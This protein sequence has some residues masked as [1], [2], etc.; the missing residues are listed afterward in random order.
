MTRSTSEGL[1]RRGFLQGTVAGVVLLGAPQVLLTAPNAAAAPAGPGYGPLLPDPA[2]RLALPK[3]FTYR[4][5]TE[6][7]KTTL[8]SGE[9]T[10][11]THDGTGAFPHGRGTVLVNNHEIGALAEAQGEVPV[12]A[13]PGLTYDPAMG[14]GCTVVETDHDG[15]RLNEYVGIAGTST[16][17][18][19]GITPWK[20]WLTCEE[21]STRAGEDGATRDH[22][23]VFEVD[24]FDRK[25]NADPTPV[26]A[27]GRY[28][29]EAA[30]VDPHTFDL[31]LTED[32]A[33]PNGLF[34]RW[35]APDGFRGGKGVLR[36]LGATDG[37]L[38]AMRCRTEDGA[39][40]DDLSRGTEIGTT[41]RVEWVPV[42]DRDAAT[43]PTREQFGD[44]QVT[45]GRKLEGMW[46]GDGGAYVVTSFA[47][48]EDSPVPH[49]GQVW[50]YDPRAATLTLKVRFGLN[51]DP[52]AD[53]AF[54][55]PDNITVSPWGGLILAEDGEGVQHL[56]GVSGDGEAYPLARNEVDG[57]EFTAPVYSH[58]KK[59]LFANVQTPGTMFAIT[60]P[61]RPQ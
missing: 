23:Y 6:A 12:P 51:P 2:G 21:D 47:R 50:F 30:A 20:T 14:G 34:Y 9:P 8:E 10:P 39:H 11:G 25:A 43:V 22:G 26:K 7:G 44:D 1:S 29:H 38:A 55:G 60:G 54:D 42:P 16:N 13:L 15:A 28:D 19:G 56:I 27:F 32:A 4:I 31:Y 61:W 58:D 41:F 5:V 3:G 40:V 46:W 35:A 17:C 37:E 33:G 48:A 52:D 53:G 36:D 45:R 24:P 49:D 18:A 57:S 59:V